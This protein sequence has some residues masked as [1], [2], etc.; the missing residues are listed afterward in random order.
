MEGLHR[1]YICLDLSCLFKLLVGEGARQAEGSPRDEGVWLWPAGSP[2]PVPL[3]SGPASAFTH[4]ST[5]L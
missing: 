1:H 4:F 3:Q 5:L 2:A